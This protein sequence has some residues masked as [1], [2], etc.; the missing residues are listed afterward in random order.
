M[1]ESHISVVEA[2]LALH[3]EEDII[4]IGGRS[5]VTVEKNAHDIGVSVIP[6]KRG[7]YLGLD[8]AFVVLSVG[9]ENRRYGGI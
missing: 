7:F 2:Q 3:I 1:T 4:E 9:V 8:T 6:H 5:A